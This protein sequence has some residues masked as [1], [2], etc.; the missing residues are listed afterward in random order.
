MEEWIARRIDSPHRRSSRAA[1]RRRAA[2]I[3]LV[4]EYIEGQT[5][6]QWMIDHPKPDLETVR[7]IVEQIAKGLQRL[8]PPG[9]A[10]PGHAAPRTS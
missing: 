1:A 6:A 4:M 8:P 5:L 7:G 9:D 10:A 2:T 3:Y